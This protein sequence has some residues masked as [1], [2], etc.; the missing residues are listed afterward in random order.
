VAVED[1]ELGCNEPV[2]ILEP[3]VVAGNLSE[4][5]WLWSNGSTQPSIEV[6]SPGHYSVLVDD[7]CTEQ[8]YMIDVD[9]ADELKKEDFFFVPNVFSPNNDGINETL[10]VFPG[11][12]LIIRNFEFRIFDRWGALL[13]GTNT[14]EDSWDGFFRG[15][16]MESG[17]YV[18]YL[19]ADVDV[20]GRRNVSMLNK[21][22]VTIV[23]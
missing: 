3:T 8:Q 10:Q 17:V 1:Q 21:G 19:K 4:I 22:D 13:F 18:W 5:K 15:V 12:D 14:P 16:L 2:A 6:S 9:W 11:P 20:C 7:G 23:R